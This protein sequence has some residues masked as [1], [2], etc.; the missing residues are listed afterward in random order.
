MGSAG[1]LQ[2]CISWASLALLYYDYTLTFSKEVRYIWGKRICLSNVAYVGC[3]YAL[4]ANV[5][6]LLA[7]S[8]KLGLGAFKV[9]FTARTYAVYCQ[10]RFVLAYLAALGLATVITDAMHVPV[11]QCVNSRSTPVLLSIHSVSLLRSLLTIVFETSSALLITVR[12]VRS[13]RAYGPW[14]SDKKNIMYLIFEEGL[15]YFGLISFF[16]VATFIL[17]LRPPAGPYRDILNAFTLPLSG[18]LTARF[19]LDLKGWNSKDQEEELSRL[20]PP[21]EYNHSPRQAQGI[22][23]WPPPRLDPP[24]L[25]THVAEFGEDPEVTARRLKRA[26][27]LEESL[28]HGYGTGRSDTRAEWD[29]VHTDRDGD[30]WGRSTEREDV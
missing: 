8:N 30:T 28:A 19:I 13:F 23:S 7:K 10:N 27:T 21:R 9:T 4:V 25:F 18:I 20:E 6:F 14:K 3:R 17:K 1:F 24:F 16:T 26:A 2:N 29:E 11:Q 15:V 12:T 22:P 5:L